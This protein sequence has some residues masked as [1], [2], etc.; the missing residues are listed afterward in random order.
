MTQKVKSRFGTRFRSEF[1]FGFDLDS[2]HDILPFSPTESDSYSDDGYEDTDGGDDESGADD[3]RGGGDDD[4][5]GRD[6][7]EEEEDGEEELSEET[8]THSHAEG[9]D[10]SAGFACT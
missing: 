10:T 7:N 4:G 6:E 9:D 2:A 5:N 1:D 3:D 8:H